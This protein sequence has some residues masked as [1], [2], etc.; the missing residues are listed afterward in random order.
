MAWGSTEYFPATDT[1]VELAKTLELQFSYEGKVDA[2]NFPR[3]GASSWHAIWRAAFGVNATIAFI[4]QDQVFVLCRFH[5]QRV[6][7]LRS[8]LADKVCWASAQIAKILSTKNSSI[9]AELIAFETKIDKPSRAPPVGL[10]G[11][12][13]EP[14]NDLHAAG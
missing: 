1:W 12:P 5:H 4:P 14:W 2:Q 6:R 9:K 13:C 8:V 10:R 7:Q 3:F 11:A